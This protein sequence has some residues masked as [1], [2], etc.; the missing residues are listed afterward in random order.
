MSKHYNKIK[1]S[2][3]EMWKIVFLF[4]KTWNWSKTSRSNIASEINLFFKN[5]TFFRHLTAVFLLAVS[6]KHF[7]PQI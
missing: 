2:L 6:F 1:N 7:K 3:R 4:K 5:L